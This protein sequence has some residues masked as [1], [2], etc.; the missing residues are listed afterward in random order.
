MKSSTS[1]YITKRG[2]KFT[3]PDYLPAYPVREATDKELNDITLFDNCN[4]V[5][6]KHDNGLHIYT[7]VE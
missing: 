1:E 6:R 5:L 3:P 4:V 7:K 2:V